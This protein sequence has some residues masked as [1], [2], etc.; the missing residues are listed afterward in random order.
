MKRSRFTALHRPLDGAE[1]E[2]RIRSAGHGAGD[3]SRRKH[4]RSDGTRDE[5]HLDPDGHDGATP[6]LSIKGAASAVEFYKK[7]FGAT[8]TMCMAGSDGKVQHA[9]LKIGKASIMLADEF[10]EMGFRSPQSIGGS[11]VVLHV[12]VENVD[13]FLERAVAAGAKV[14]RPVADQFYGDRV[15]MLTD[16]FGHLWSFATHVEDVSPEE[17]EKRSEAYMSQSGGA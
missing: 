10:P 11:P 12:Y 15:V 5:G 1:R 16:P 3:R 17:M 6:Y 8:E 7:G 2:S 4:R 13:A 9:E 14:L